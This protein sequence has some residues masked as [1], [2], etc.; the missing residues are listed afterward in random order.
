VARLHLERAEPSQAKSLLEPC[1]RA[2]P[3][4]AKLPDLVAA[5][6]LLETTR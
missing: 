1:S 2:F 3:A 6:S 5:R 4:D